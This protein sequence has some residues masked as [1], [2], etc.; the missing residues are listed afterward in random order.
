MAYLSQHQS[1]ASATYR[2]TVDQVAAAI[3]NLGTVAGSAAQAATNHL[4]QTLLAEAA[5]L[6]YM[7]VFMYCAL[8]AFAFVPLTFLFS[9]VKAARS[10]GGH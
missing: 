5:Y 7:D 6:A 4:Y 9:P 8:L 2:G 10:S 3:R 1:Q